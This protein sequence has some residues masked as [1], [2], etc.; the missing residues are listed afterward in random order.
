LPALGDYIGYIISEIA[1]A[2]FQADLETIRIAEMYASHPLLKNMAVPHFR[3]PTINL[4]FP[5][6]IKE[7]ETPATKKVTRSQTI[8]KMRTSFDKNLQSQLKEAGLVLSKQQAVDL[9]KAINKPFSSLK[10]TE[11]MP[12]SVTKVIDDSASAA[13]EFVRKLSSENKI[14]VSSKTISAIEDELK[15]SARGQLVNYLKL[16]SRL[17]IS[18]NTDELKQAQAPELMFK[19][20]LSISESTVEWAVIDT[21]GK[22]VSKLVPE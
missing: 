17:N 14:E 4:D 6:V 18:M 21:D 3:L 11:G 9:K 15:M 5:V 2:R 1:N 8:A 16:T 22:E 7:I 13:S 12:I 19:I 20:H 10:L